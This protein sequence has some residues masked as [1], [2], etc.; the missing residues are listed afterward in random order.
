[1]TSL[2]QLCQ[3]Q[4]IFEL[5]NSLDALIHEIKIW[6]LVSTYTTNL[7]PHFAFKR[8]R[9]LINSR[10]SI[11][12]SYQLKGISSSQ[13]FNDNDFQTTLVSLE[14]PFNRISTSV[15]TLMYFV[16]PWEIP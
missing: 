14:D 16:V 5:S 2:S 8:S 1:M 7:Y 12:S 3:I 11:S 6:L 4:D 9:S 15:F 10:P 13:S